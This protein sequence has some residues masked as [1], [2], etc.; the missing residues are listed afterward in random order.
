MVKILDCPERQTQCH[1]KSVRRPKVPDSD[2]TSRPR[3][4]KQK[5]GS[6]D[7][8]VDHSDTVVVATQTRLDASCTKMCRRSFLVVSGLIAFDTPLE[9]YRATTRDA[10]MS[11][12]T[13]CRPHT[14]WASCEIRKCGPFILKQRPLFLKTPVS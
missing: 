14:S 11:S 7:P 3:F 5:R 8:L 9:L 13:P 12:L 6:F 1:E 10:N 2:F 4:S